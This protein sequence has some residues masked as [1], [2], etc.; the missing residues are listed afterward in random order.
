MAKV[1]YSRPVPGSHGYELNGNQS[2]H[3]LGSRT[4][5]RPYRPIHVFRSPLRSPSARMTDPLVPLF[6]V[7][8]QAVRLF[9]LR[10]S[11]SRKAN[12]RRKPPVR[13]L[14]DAYFQSARI[15]AA[16]HDRYTERIRIFG[17]FNAQRHVAP[18]LCSDGQESDE[19]SQTYLLTAERRG[20][21]GRRT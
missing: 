12:F 21:N 10:P 17:F 7:Q 20:V 13:N 15:G 9:A 11:I 2:A 3:G 6:D 5:T 14:H 18:A 4:R 1:E 19:K 8:R 16:R